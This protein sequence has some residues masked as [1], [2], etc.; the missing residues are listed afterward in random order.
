MR[1]PGKHPGASDVRLVHQRRRIFRPRE[2]SEGEG[3]GPQPNQ[4]NRSAATASAAST[5]RALDFNI[6]ASFSEVF[7]KSSSRR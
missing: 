5:C 1:S 6:T 2:G 7:L 3:M 4:K